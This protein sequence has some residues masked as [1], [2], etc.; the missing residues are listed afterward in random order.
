MSELDDIPLGVKVEDRIS[1]AKG[2]VIEKAEH[3]SGCNRIAVREVDETPHKGDK[4]HFF[5]S[6]LNIISENTEFTEDADD[7]ITESEHLK[8]G[9]RARDR[10][11][12]ATGIIAIINTGLYKTPDAAL[13]SCDEESNETTLEWFDDVRL[14]VVSSEPVWSF[15]D[16]DR[17]VTEE[18][19]GAFGSSS[20]DREFSP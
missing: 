16:T 7:V 8:L 18:T 14:E 12:A 3:I 19:T 6:Q 1:N 11:T 2:I 13:V 4:S 17:E 9:Y 15:D 5:P 20:P 10:V